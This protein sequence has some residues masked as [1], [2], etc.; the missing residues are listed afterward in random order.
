L[1]SRL[2]LEVKNQVDNGD[3]GL[4]CFAARLWDQKE[5]MN[6]DLEEISYSQPSSY[7]ILRSHPNAR[8][9]VAGTAFEAGTDTLA[10]STLWF[11]MAMA[12]YP[13][14]MKKAQAELD[15]VL[16]EGTMPRLS[17]LNDLPYC[18]AVTKEVFR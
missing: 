2:V 17:D 7:A 1:Y 14:V 12:L 3:I 6:L 16:G 10:S 11:L 15:R 18:V 13:D 9:L 4:E 5:K 8:D